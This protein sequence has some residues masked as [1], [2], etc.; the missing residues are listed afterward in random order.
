V[1][2]ADLYAFDHRLEEQELSPAAR[3]R[4]LASVK[5]LLSFGHRIGVFPVN[6]GTDF[7][8]VPPPDR[9]AERRLSPAAQRALLTSVARSWDRTLVHLLLATG[10]RVSEVVALTWAD[11]APVAESGQVRVVDSRN[12]ERVLPLPADLWQEL[13]DLRRG[14][15]SEPVFPSATTGGRMRRQEINVLVRR[16][17]AEAGLGPGVSPSWLRHAYAWN[18]LAEGSTLAEI[19]T[20]LGHRHLQ[21]TRRYLRAAAEQDLLSVGCIQSPGRDQ[22]ARPRCVEVS[23]GWPDY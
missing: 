13:Q 12:V 22:S 7:K 19:Q 4:A 9:L 10:I 14:T 18:A 11:L 21:A 17:A 3:A 8:V 15:D 23:G 1:T 20:S 6:A 5:S 16:A 2:L